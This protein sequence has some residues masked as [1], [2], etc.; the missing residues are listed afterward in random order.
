[1]AAKFNARSPAVKRIMQEMKEMQSS[2]SSDFIA[3]ALESDIFEW[4]FVI[5]GPPETEFEGGIY[6]G[7]VLLP[8]EYPFKPPAFMM[9]TPSGRFETN[10]KICLSISSHHPEHWQPSWSIRTALTALIAFMPSPG[11]GAL[12]SLDYTKEERKKL[13]LRAR[14]TA[15]TFGSP[16]RQRVID[17]M[18]Q[19]MLTQLQASSLQ[20]SASSSASTLL[21]P[22]TP[23]EPVTATDVDP[24]AYASNDT[25]RDGQALFDASVNPKPASYPFPASSSGLD[26]R[27]STANIPVTGGEPGENKAPTTNSIAANYHDVLEGLSSES[28]EQTTDKTAQASLLSTSLHAPAPAPAASASVM[29]QQAPAAAAAAASASDHGLTILALLLSMGIAAILVR[30]AFLVFDQGEGFPEFEL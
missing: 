11:Q 24:V 17:E 14:Q 26:Q 27:S 12:G 30:K 18:H 21:D 1:M 29:Y 9:L 22:A 20:V 6:H 16:E 13:A 28:K 23:T 8:P 4:H 3:E 5:R 2:I 19:R 25:E 15:P 10:V 7:R